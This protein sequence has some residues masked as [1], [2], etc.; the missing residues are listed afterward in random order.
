MSRRFP[1]SSSRN[2]Q[3]YR[4]SPDKDVDVFRRQVAELRDKRR[5]ITSLS[6]HND[7]ALKVSTW[8]AGTSSASALPISGLMKLLKQ[9]GITVIDASDASQADVRGHSAFAENADILRAMRN[10]FSGQVGRRR[11]RL[12]PAGALNNVAVARPINN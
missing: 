4:S 9:Y 10:N 5:E 2:V 3:R 6:S 11:G 12:L 7:L 1:R 8:L